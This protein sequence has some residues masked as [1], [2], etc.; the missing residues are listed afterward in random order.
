MNKD[1]IKPGII[2]KLASGGPQMTVNQVT[3]IGVECWWF[4]KQGI[5]KKALFAPESL[6]PVIAKILKSKTIQD[7]MQTK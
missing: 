7:V 6:V 2:V 3:S 1:D 5:A 4:D